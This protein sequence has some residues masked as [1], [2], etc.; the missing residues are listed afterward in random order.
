MVGKSFVLQ[1]SSMMVD[2]ELLGAAEIADLLGVTRQRV[3]Q[4]SHREDFPA[5]VVRLSAGIIWRGSE[6]RAWMRAT[7]RGWRLDDED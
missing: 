7:G 2:E 4:L 1:R 5:P 3:F 6:V